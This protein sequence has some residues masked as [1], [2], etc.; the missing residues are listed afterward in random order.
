MAT[1]Q[2]GCLCGKVRYS[3][4]A[5]PIFTGVCHCHNC[6]KETGSAFAVSVGV[7]KPTLTV[8]GTLK[9][10]TDRGDSG[11]PVYRKFCPECGSTVI[12]EVAVMP[13]I[14]II[15]AGTLDD[16]SAVRPGMHIYCASKQD[17]TEIPAGAKSFPQMP[18]RG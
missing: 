9:T 6:Q 17:W 18:T 10:Y 12:T 1:M 11:Q 14:T 4:A 16:T 15:A 2:G 5:D 8:T 7:P 13:D 3:I